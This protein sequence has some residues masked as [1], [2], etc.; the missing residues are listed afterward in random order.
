MP[1]N[2][3]AA[4]ANHLAKGIAHPIAIISKLLLAITLSIAH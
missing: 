3:L 4:F 2:S 1:Y